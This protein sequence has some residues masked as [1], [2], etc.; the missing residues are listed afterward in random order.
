MALFLSLG[1]RLKDIDTK[2]ATFMNAFVRESKVSFRTKPKG[3]FLLISIHPRVTCNL[4][5]MKCARLNNITLQRSLSLFAC[6]SE[7]NAEFY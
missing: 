5:F 2:V 3:I 1:T 6:F 7:H 4:R